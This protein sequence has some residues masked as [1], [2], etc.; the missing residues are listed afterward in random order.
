MG[1]KSWKKAVRLSGR[2]S[3]AGYTLI[4]LLV[5][6]AILGM[7]TAIATPLALHYLETA[8]VKTAKTEIANIA[9]CLDLFKY[10]VGRYPTT[11]E[12]LDALLKEPP[13]IENWSGPYLKKINGF[14]D[15]WGKP[16]VYHSPGEHGAFDLYSYGAKGQA[17]GAKPEI[18]N[19]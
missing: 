6:L 11:Q 14:N 2:Q 16:Y 8:K 15:P 19:W 9:A 13:N 10:D 17:T 4:E 7:L 1:C 18:A 12:G 3:D 5:V